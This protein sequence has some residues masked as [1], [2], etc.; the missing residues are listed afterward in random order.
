MAKSYK[1]DLATV[2]DRLAHLF[3]EIEKISLF[4]S[5]RHGTRSL[6]SDIDLL[7]E[8]NAY[9]RASDVRDCI[10]QRFPAVDAFLLNGNRAVS[11]LN[12]SFVE[13]DTPLQVAERLQ[14]VTF[15]T[16]HG[17]QLPGLPFPILQDVATNVVFEATS[18]PNLH[19]AEEA[20]RTL[21]KTA[22]A[23]G[24]PE[25][26]HIGTTALE[27]AEFIVEV[28]R[29]L[30]IDPDTLSKRGQAATGWTTRLKSE[31]D[32]QDLL[33]IVVKPWLPGFA[34]EEVTI[35]YDGHDK[36]ADFS[37]ANNQL[38]IE[39]KHITSTGTMASVLKT[40]KGLADFYT[41]HPN[42]RVAIFAILVEPSVQLDAARWESDYSQL[43]TAPQVRTVIL[44]NR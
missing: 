15:W 26:P 30:I 43:S 9:L 18:L 6:R 19:V 11:C 17:G 2:A 40:L 4:G 31:Y 8:T 36:K 28:M 32:F 3:P 38:V 22:A 16:R 29:R 10:L 33:W 23:N 41:R 20:R 7:I 27:C 14:A 34:R 13:A 37:Y 35:S 12:D 21:F 39:L 25:L 42:I 44:M 1:I 24:M 5:R